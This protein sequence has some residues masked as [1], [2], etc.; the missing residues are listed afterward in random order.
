MEA[1]RQTDRSHPST[2]G[3]VDVDGQSHVRNQPAT[4]VP[5][6][7]NLAGTTDYADMLGEVPAEFDDMMFGSVTSDYS[8]WGQF[9]S[10]V[11]SGLG[12]L[13][14]FLNDDPFRL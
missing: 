7:T 11:S 6:D 10:M 13:D 12:N 8:G 14:V 3:P 4:S 9:A 5:V 1:L 2:A